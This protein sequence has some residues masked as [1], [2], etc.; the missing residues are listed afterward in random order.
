[1]RMIAGVFLVLLQLGPLAGAGICMHAAPQP[2]AK[3]PMP[4]SGM[5]HESSPSHSAPAQDCAQ[6]MVCAP[7]APM[8]PVTLQLFGATPRAS[9]AYSTP[10]ALLPGDPVAPPQP[11]PIA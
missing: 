7:T 8:V 3:C 4:M 1:M 5:D 9:T 2:E 11:P 10:S 6:M